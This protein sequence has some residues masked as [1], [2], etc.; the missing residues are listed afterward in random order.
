MW[1]TFSP[2]PLIPSFR[3]QYNLLIVL[4][5]TRAFRQHPICRGQLDQSGSGSGHAPTWARVKL[6]LALRELQYVLQYITMNIIIAYKKLI[7]VF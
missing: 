5:L 7:L 2:F 6:Q 3:P 1:S 4:A